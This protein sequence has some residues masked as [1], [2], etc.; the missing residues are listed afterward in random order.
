M[1]FAEKMNLS[2]LLGYDI[3][4]VPFEIHRFVNPF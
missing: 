1:L 3:H 2:R 4:H